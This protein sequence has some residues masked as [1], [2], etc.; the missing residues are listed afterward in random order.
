MSEKESGGGG[1]SSG[2]FFIGFFVL[3]IIFAVIS[4]QKEKEAAL[5]NGESTST[6]TFFSPKS[7]PS[8]TTGTSP[9]REAEY[10]APETKPTE[11]QMTPDQIERKVASIYKELDELRE[12]LRQAR[13][14]EPASP[15]K[16][17][18]TLRR[19]NVS[20]EEPELEYL[21]LQAN[22]KNTAG[23]TISNWYLE[24]Y[25][26]EEKAFIPDGDRTLLKWRS[27][28]ETDIVLLPGETAYLV[29][30]DSPID[31]SFRENMCTGYLTTEGD[32]SPGL[33][34]QCPRPKD[35]LER[36]GNIELDN[37]RCYEFIERLGTCITPEDEM[38]TRSK[39]GGAC[40]T[41]VEKTFNY[42]DCVRLHRYDPFFAGDGY[43]R[44]YLGEGN[45][46]WRN[47]REIIRLLDENERVISVI[48]Y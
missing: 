28:L 4:G 10:R 21:I 44:V 23:V 3:L 39:I 7:S 18:V 41:F 46:L 5:K 20:T 14:R 32:F 27:P 47:E 24:S 40:A 26:T 33:R 1:G 2:G 11:R 45:A 6:P 13:L 36:F 16:D 8:N 42:N 29:T 15:A 35:E 31:V 12:D 37:D 48:E 19:G 43:W 38:S 22:N 25:V 9:S 34:R 30:G 17:T